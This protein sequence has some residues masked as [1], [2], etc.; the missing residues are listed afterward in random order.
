ME[1]VRYDRAGKWYLEPTDKSLSRQAVTVG[2]AA[3]YARWLLDSSTGSVTFGLMGGA[4]FDA[5]VDR[6]GV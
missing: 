2:D 3:K 1:V 6:G 4:R 5:I